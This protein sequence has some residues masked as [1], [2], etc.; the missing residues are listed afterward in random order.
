M[1]GQHPAQHH[2]I[3]AATKGFSNIYGR[4]AATV[5]NDLTTK[6]VSGISTFNHGGQL[7]I[8]NARF[9]ARGTDGA[10]ADADTYLR[11]LSPLFALSPVTTLPAMMVLSGHASRALLT[12]C[13]KC[14]EY[15]FATSI[16]RK[17]SAGFAIRICLVFLEIS[18]RCTG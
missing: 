8:A 2:E 16:H 12:N 15:P 7:R 6:A 3:C 5:A 14:S 17:F 13:T 9:D 10:R 18:I 4:G 11:R 1:T